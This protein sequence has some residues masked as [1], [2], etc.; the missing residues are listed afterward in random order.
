MFVPAPARAQP[1]YERASKS[2]L[3]VLL[4]QDNW[5]LQFLDSL[6]H[7]VLLPETRGANMMFSVPACRDAN[8]LKRV[9]MD[10]T[11]EIATRVLIHCRTLMEPDVR[12]D[13]GAKKIS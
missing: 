4:A 7:Q 8:M 12:M 2:A 5:A 9:L 13:R 3:A 10:R 11:D 6:V 1:Q